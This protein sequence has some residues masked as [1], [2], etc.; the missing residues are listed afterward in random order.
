MNNEQ[1]AIY[2]SMRF[3]AVVNIV[4]GVVVLVTGVVSGTMLLISAGKLLNGKSQLLF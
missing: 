3:S 1:E 2:R 4:L